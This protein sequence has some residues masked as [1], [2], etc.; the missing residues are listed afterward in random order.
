[1]AATVMWHGERVAAE[2]V[3]L[4]GAVV[5]KLSFDIEAHA[6]DNAPVDTGYLRRSIF[7]TPAGHLGVEGTA[8][9]GDVGG[10]G[11]LEG[12]LGL[13]WIVMASAEYAAYVELGTVNA[14]AQPYLMP[15]VDAVRG[16]AGGELSSAVHLGSSDPES[17]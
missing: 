11:D 3:A 1:M 17:S 6:K 4:A 13:T 15:A 8:L 12:E 9:V 7:A 2:V 14:G 5:G 16:A 10:G